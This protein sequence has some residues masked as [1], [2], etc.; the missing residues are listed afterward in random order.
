[1]Q[2]NPSTEFEWRRTCMSM[3]RDTPVRALEA[4]VAFASVTLPAGPADSPRL[5]GCHSRTQLRLEMNSPNSWS[6]QNEKK[7]KK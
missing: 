4:Q 5:H 2:N 7:K 6:L 1:M 3:K